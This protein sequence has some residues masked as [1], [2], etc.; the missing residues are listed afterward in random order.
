MSAD[1]V[2]AVTFDRVAGY[3]RERG[4]GFAPTPAGLAGT[5]DAHHLWF[6]L[7][8]SRAD[9]LQVRGR[10][11]A[12][13]PV[14]DRVAVLRALNDWNRARVWPKVYLRAEGTEAT[15]HVL[16][17]ELSTDVR[18]GLTDAQLAVQLSTALVAVTAALNDLAPALGAPP[19][20]SG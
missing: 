20:R 15:E 2:S 12:P 16:Y 13:V 9:V 18:H 5:W 4:Y 10:A 8:G 7:Q 19:P 3:L 11:V 6:L 14:R 1:D 17:A